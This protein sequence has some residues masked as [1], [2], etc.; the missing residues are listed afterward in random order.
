MQKKE[1]KGLIKTVDQNHSPLKKRKEMLNF[2]R[3]WLLSFLLTSGFAIIPVIFFAVIDYNVTQRLTLSETISRT[4]RLTSNSWRSVSFFLN[5]HQ[6][7]LKYIVE[8]NSYQDLNDPVRLSEILGNL[9]NSF[10]GFSD[11]GVINSEGI[12]RTYVGPYQL[13]GKNY[14]GQRW[15]ENVVSQGKFISDVFLGFRNVPHLVIAIKHESESGTSYVLRATIEHKL[16]RI[17][18]EVSTSIHQ[19]SPNDS[20]R[21]IDVF[22]VNHIGVLQTESSHFGDVLDIFP[23]PVP[24]FSDKTEVIESQDLQM[25]NIVIGYRYI[26]ETPFILM[27]AKDKGRLMIPWRESRI[28]LLQYLAISITVVILWI[29]GITTYLTKRLR[30]TDRR[31]VKYLHMAE[32]SNKLASIGR[33]AAG[34]AH[35]INNPLAIINEKAGLVKDIFHFQKRYQEDPKLLDSMDSILHSV[36]RC[37]RITRQLLSFARHMDISVQQINLESLINEVLSFLAKEAEYRFIDVVVNIHKDFPYF[38]SDRGKLQQIFLNIINNA[39]AS[40]TTGGAVRIEAEVEGDRI[41]IEISDTGC[42]ISK[43]NME[44]IFEPFFSTKTEVGGT[45]LGLSI[46]YSL[47]Q[48]LG[49]RI[50][51]SS[52]VGKGTRFTIILPMKLKNKDG[53]DARTAG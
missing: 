25:K 1:T 51:V 48:E 6:N 5:E 36:E 17:L 39:F 33:L 4:A 2:K 22:L 32:Y 37:G 41:R 26:P 44:Y 30:E 34:V 8:E 50:E 3:I 38:E 14:S 46:T 45:G 29:L 28:E 52:K 21:N 7:A 40:M 10:G 9:R 13:E 24:G 43:E 49:G 27:I 23:I 16:D 18:S 12:Q 15:F 53:D 35:E 11:L 31:R 19:T 20:R 42:G 47:V